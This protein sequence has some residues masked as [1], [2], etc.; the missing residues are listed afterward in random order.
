MREFGALVCK[1]KINVYKIIIND[2]VYYK[3]KIWPWVYNADVIL[4]VAITKQ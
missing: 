3:V 1:F 4:M 2:N